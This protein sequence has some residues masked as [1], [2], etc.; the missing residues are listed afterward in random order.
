[1]FRANSGLHCTPSDPSDPPPP[2]KKR[3]YRRTKNISMVAVGQGN[4]GPIRSPS[5][6]MA[7]TGAPSVVRASAPILL[8]CYITRLS[9]LRHEPYAINNHLKVMVTVTVAVVMV[10]DTSTAGN[11]RPLRYGLDSSNSRQTA[12][13]PFHLD[14]R[15]PQRERGV[16]LRY[17]W[18][19]RGWGRGR[20]RGG[21]SRNFPPGK[22]QLE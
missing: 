21:K 8:C 6:P 15:H 17:A 7:D 2:T 5:R 22:T 18:P 13:L 3:K 19:G 20:G 10:E 11:R 12:V 4:T 9:W 1:M 16:V 14:Y